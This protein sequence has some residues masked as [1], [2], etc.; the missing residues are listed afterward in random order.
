MPEQG[1]SFACGELA[2]AQQASLH[3]LHGP[4][5]LLQRGLGGGLDDVVAPLDGG[6][7]RVFGQQAVL[8]GL[9]RDVLD[10]QDF[11]VGLCCRI[12]ERDELL[13]LVH[14]V[15]LA[16][17]YRAHA[18]ALR[19]LDGAAVRVERK[20]ARSG[21]AFVERREGSPEQE[22][23][24]ACQDGQ[25]AQACGRDARARPAHDVSSRASAGMCL[26]T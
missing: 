11:K 1:L 7:A 18:T 10:A 2:G 12:V 5:L 4:D 20:V 21:N 26:A 17:G 25:R 6:L 3:V 24:E 19:L 15:A 8:L 9:R 22:A 16:H 23:A 14:D 13:P